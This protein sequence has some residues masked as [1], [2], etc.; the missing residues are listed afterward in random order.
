MAEGVVSVLGGERTVLWQ[1]MDMTGESEVMENVPVNLKTNLS[2]F[3][4]VQ[5]HRSR[6]GKGRGGWMHNLRYRMEKLSLSG[7]IQ[8][9]LQ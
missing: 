4:S 9:D 5:R 7:E 3:E 1:I 8:R 2:N 6:D